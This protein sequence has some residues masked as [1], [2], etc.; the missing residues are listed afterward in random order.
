MSKIKK[1]LDD[2]GFF[3]DESDSNNDY[4]DYNCD[5]NIDFAKEDELIEKDLP[6]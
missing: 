2:I 6:F 4:Y 3:E 5:Y 1:Y